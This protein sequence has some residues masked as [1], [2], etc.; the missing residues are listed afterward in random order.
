MPGVRSWRRTACARPRRG[1][2]PGRR[3]RRVG[4]RRLPPRS[5]RG[6]R[7]AAPAHRRHH[8][9][10][11]RRHPR[12][13]RSTAAEPVRIRW[14]QGIAVT[15]TVRELDDPLLSRVWGAR[16]TRIGLDVTGRADAASHG[17]TGTH[18]TRGPPPM[19]DHNPPR[20]SR[21]RP[22]CPRARG[23][24]PR[25]G[26][27][28]L[29]A[30]RRARRRA[31]HP[32]PRP[33]P[34]GEGGPARARARRSA[35]P[36]RAA[37]P[38]EPSRRSVGA[39]TSAIA[40]LVPSL[41]YYWPS[42]VRGAEEEARRRGFRV[43]VRGASYELQDERPMLERLVHAENVRGLILA[44]NT[45][46][47]HAQDVIQWLAECGG[48]ERARRTRRVVLPGS[49]RSSRSPPTMPSA[50]VLAVRHLAELGHR[51][52]GLVLS[53]NSPTSRKI[54]AGWNAACE[55]L[56]L[57]AGT[58][59]RVPHPRPQHPRVL[60]RGQ[61]H[62][63]HGARDGHDRAAR[64]SRPRGDGLRRPRAQPGDLGARRPVDHRLRRRGG[65]AVQPR[66]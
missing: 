38:S 19:S 49:A 66:R 16:L 26:G 51:R 56:G 4:S 17:R 2:C 22:P 65:P 27:P 21:A 30:D 47:P 37:C 61:R 45:D 18:D 64:A 12:D 7:A 39:A 23:A 25:R 36:R 33:R 20:A 9:T 44:P 24:L 46:M 13:V 57:D 32:A 29:P 62:P 8:R 1:R 58:A 55:E 42:V 43:I 41:N 35:C 59:L 11:R 34:A 60:R 5:G 40:V 54:A 15:R 14:P 52:V 50:A 48:A 28:G 31:R 63:R 6:S 3:R 53:R 10:R